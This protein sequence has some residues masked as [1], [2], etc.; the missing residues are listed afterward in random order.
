MQTCKKKRPVCDSAAALLFILLL[1]IPLQAATVVLGDFENS[2]D[3]W[4]KDSTVTTAYSTQGVTRGTQSLQVTFPDG[5]IGVLKKNMLSQVDLLK[6]MTSLTLNVTT[7]NDSGQIP[8]GWLSLFFIINSQTGGWQQFN[9]SYPGIP[10][11]PRT[12]TLTVT[13]P[14]SV[15]DTFIQSGTGGWAEFILITNS[16]SGGGVLWLDNICAVTPESGPENVTIQVNAGA[17]IRTIPMT[18][19]G[20]NL[21]AWDGAQTGTNSAFNNL[22]KASGRKY[23]R[24]PGG[25]WG[26]GHLWSDIEGPNGAN[27][28]KVS[29]NETLYLLSQLSQPGQEVPPTLQPIVNFP[30]WWYDT[31]QDDTPGDDTNQNYAIAHQRAVA[32]AVAWVQDQTSRPVCARYWEIGNEIGGPWE[33]GYFPEISG[34]FYGDYF[35]DFYL[36]MKAVNPTIKIGACAEP[37][38]E[39]QPWGWYQG[40][41]TYDTLRA[42]F[43][44]GVV[45]DFLIIH[46][47]PGTGETASYN[48]TLL[49]TDINNIGVYTAN[50]D[51]IV[52]NAIGGQY[53]GQVR[54]AMTEWDAGGH[55]SYDRV[56]CYVNALFHAQYILEMAKHNWDVS[57]PWIPDYGPGFSVYPVWYVNPL[58]IYYFGRDM[59]QASSSDSP[60]VRAYAAKDAAGNLTIFAANN[61]P[62]D[63]VTATVNIAGFQAG[64]GGQQWLIEP[65]GSLIAGGVNIQD[66]NS[67]S[68]NGIVNPDPLTAPALPSQPFASG[69]TFTIALPASCMLLLKIP[70]A[71][72][73]TTPPAAPSGLAAVRQV[74]NVHLD[75]NDN[76]E[77]DLAGY[78][79]YRSTTSGSGYQKINGTLTADSQYVDTGTES[80]R[81]YYYVVRAVDTSWNESAA[82]GEQAVTLPAMSL[83]S[84]LREWWTGISGSAVSQLTSHPNYPNNPSGRQQISLLEGPVNWADNYGTRIRGY[85][86]PPTSGNYTFWIA[87]DDNC[88]LRLSTTGSPAQ[89]ALIA[90]VTSWTD[91][92]QWDKF[93]SQRSSPVFLTAGR[94]YYIEVLHK[95]NTGGDNIAVAWEGPGI[96]QEVIPGRYL[97][98]WFTDLYGDFD[99]SGTVSVTDLSELADVWLRDDCAWTSRIDLDGDCVVNGYEFSEFAKNWLR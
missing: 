69:N 53:V 62:T 74:V 11:S 54:Y 22:M 42:A 19:Y 44:K 88:Q 71:T 43:Q 91:S 56:T 65:A 2:M 66:K 96:A 45:P 73:D 37:K 5:W 39:L 98:P 3:G 26:N 21:Q 8:G 77:P 63:A 89:A 28:W 64:A 59:V 51:W 78:N 24:V 90:Q 60:L 84:I 86:Y 97:S 27:A 10:S 25:S 36:A 81:T 31:L 15:R 57:N 70:A 48:P 33:V 50:L 30:G 49:S 17:P 93:S 6:T 52:T 47:Y 83:G 32:A 94:K 92:R 7:R 75:W 72:G 87:G 14:Q 38:H 79:V 29:Y 46:A 76:A 55:S 99:N 12:D 18:L 13:I 68:I 34:T 16:G 80:G 41:W 61:S 95:E 40:Y 82:S 58:L 20:A 1:S 67:I 85:L 35:A 23:F 4:T 9:L